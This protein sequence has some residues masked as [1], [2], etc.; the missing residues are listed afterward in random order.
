MQ[1]HQE[2]LNSSQGKLKDP[3][4]LF[5][6]KRSRTDEEIRISNETLYAIDKVVRR[7]LKEI[8]FQHRVNINN[9]SIPID[10]SLLK[11]DTPLAKNQTDNELNAEL[12]KVE[13]EEPEESNELAMMREENLK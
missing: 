11:E 5:E 6:P 13:V 7:K 4:C 12:C 10:L 2:I 3:I 8:N 9:S 1:I